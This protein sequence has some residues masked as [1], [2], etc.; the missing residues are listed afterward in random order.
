[1]D[2]ET[3]E[4]RLKIAGKTYTMRIPPEKEEAYRLAER[5]INRHVA[6]YENARLDGYGLTDYLAM[7]ALQLAVS[8]I[9]MAQ[10]RQVGDEDMQRIAELSDAVKRHLER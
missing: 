7:V 9:L 6:E 3:L 8:N 4:I 10:S 1:M 2:G 5:V